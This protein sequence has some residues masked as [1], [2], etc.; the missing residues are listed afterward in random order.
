VQPII[1]GMTPRILFAERAARWSVSHRR[2]AI[3][4]WLVFVI[5]AVAIGGSIGT[6]TLSIADSGIGESGRADRTLGEHGFATPPTER[7]LVRG[8]GA[9]AAAADLAQRLKADEPVASPDGHSLLVQTTLP[10]KVDDAAD[11]VAPLEAAVAATERAHPRAELLQAGEG[12]TAKAFEERLEKDF[13]RAELSAV[14]LTLA[15]LAI[16]FGA[17]MAAVVPVLLGLSAVAAALGLVALPSQA[18]AMDQN[19]SSIV[20]LIGLAVGVDYALFYLRREREERAAGREKDAAI[21]AAART[22]GHAILVS[23][24]TVM[25][26]VAGMF[27]SDSPYY[28]SYATG[29]IIVVAVAMIGSVSVLPAVLSW[30]GHRVEKGSLPLIGRRKRAAG[31]SRAWTWVLD[32]VMGRPAIA[33]TGAIVVLLAMASPVLGLNLADQG[34]KSLPS[35]LPVRTAYDEIDKAFPGGAMPV[36]VAVTGDVGSADG[37]AALDTL[38]RRVDADAHFGAPVVVDVNAGGTAARVAIPLVGNGTDERSQDALETL[39]EEILPA[40]LAGKHLNADVTGI[41]AMSVDGR[42]DT[43]GRGPVVVGLVL[44][45]MFGILLV[46][47]RSAVVAAKAIVLNVLS[48]AAAYGV[49]VLVFQHGWGDSLLGFEATGSISTWVPMFMFLLL[50]GLSMD[51]HV[52]ILSRIREAVDGGMSTR[53]AVHHGL[54]TTAG[55]VT[56]AAVVMVGVFGIFATLSLIEV[57]QIGVGLAVA[58]LIDATIVR[59]ILLPAAMALLGEWNWWLPRPLARRLG[60]APVA[61]P[62]RA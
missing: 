46:T 56:S 38:V 20:L 53:D 36:T 57:K 23:G 1:V 32:R 13:Q 5:A 9:E 50:F 51:Y 2:R 4:G 30:L 14:P 58:V 39:R 59:A 41:T 18:F 34:A 62:A 15:I 24:F 31:E 25:A 60:R 7:I 3:V 6:N 8:A 48:V 16:A 49:L 55:V 35:D 52:F 12:S 11:H 27:I 17:L 37:H 47:F 54:R 61:E 21:M 22:S 26:A 28:R 43:F 44:T 40:T 29:I 10:G 42:A 45:L 19:I 33:A